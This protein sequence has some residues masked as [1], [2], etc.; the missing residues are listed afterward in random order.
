MYQDHPEVDSSDAQW[1]RG[2]QSVE[3]S[4]LEAPSTPSTVDE[5]HQPEPHQSGT[6]ETSP[7]MPSHGSYDAIL[8]AMAGNGTR[9]YK[10]LPSEGADHLF[11]YQ[12][13]GLGSDRFCPCGDEPAR[14]DECDDEECNNEASFYLASNMLARAAP[15]RMMAL[16]VTLLFE[17]PVLMMIS[18][19][20]GA[21]CQLIG[22]TR[23]QLMMGFIPLN[24][25]ISGNV[26]LQAS[27]L[28]TR[29]ISHRHVTSKS[30]GDWYW[31]EVGAAAYLGLGMGLLLGTIAFFCSG[32]DLAFGLTICLAQFIS[33]VTAGITGTFAPL[34]FSFL[35]NRDSGKW[36]GPLETAIQDIVG[37]FAMVVISYHLLLFLGPHEI[38]P[39]D[40]CAGTT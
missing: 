5:E 34:L 25:A 33:I 1:R 18:G 35:F 22:R 16:L 2:S 28:T 30:Y 27:T 3:A 29:A 8:D 36:G 9:Q 13:G 32:K 20:S 14:H 17:I 21:L 15:E 23:Y 6:G 4:A 26:G 12:D 24:S 19:R 38:A 39:G 7:L 11:G 37:S 40:V 31:K 10:R